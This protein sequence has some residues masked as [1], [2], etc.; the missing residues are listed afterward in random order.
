[1]HHTPIETKITEKKMVISTE[2]VKDDLSIICN[3]SISD[4]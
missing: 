3:L 1:M 2:E 4:M